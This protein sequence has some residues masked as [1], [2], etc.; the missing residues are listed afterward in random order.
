MIEKV[1]DIVKLIIREKD[2]CK[3]AVDMTFGKGFDSKFILENPNIEK[4]YAF[5]IQEES[6]NFSK[7]LIKDDKR[8]NFF[9]ESHA[10]IDKIVKEKIDLAVYNL[11][12]LPGAD[13]SITTKTGST[14]ESLRKLLA[15]LNKK[16]LIIITVYTGHEEG[17]K[18]ASA[19]ETFIKEIDPKVYP[20]LKI[21]YENRPNNPPYILLIGKK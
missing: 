9:L 8:F 13:K 7:Q 21:G 20:V 14:L 4:L 19:L 16:G 3:I 15:L 12:F 6:Q 18:E 1:T 11:G 5:D 10:N 2:D 17:K